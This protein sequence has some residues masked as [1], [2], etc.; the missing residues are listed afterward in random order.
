MNRKW[1]I[2]GGVLA[3]VAAAVLVFWYFRAREEGAWICQNGEWVEQGEPVGAKPTWECEEGE[4]VVNSE[5]KEEEV[6]QAKFE[7][8]KE[9]AQEAVESSPT[10]KYDGYDL[11][12]ESSE[13]LLCPH[14]W[15]FTFS[16]SSRHGDYGDRSG[17]FLAQ[18]K[19]SHMI[20]VM[21]E[22]EKVVAVVTDRTFD[23]LKEI[24]LK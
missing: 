24:Y 10:F 1:M 23:E 19:T 3:F 5:E 7:K 9:I 14:C 18:M 12:F 11:K 15:E 16:F 13:A 22:D 4:K 2:I 8:S 17:Q 6:N 20:R 21:V